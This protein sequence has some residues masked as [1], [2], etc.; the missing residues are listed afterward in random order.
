MKR[1]LVTF[2]AVVSLSFGVAA[3]VATV[4]DARSDNGNCSERGGTNNS[5][6]DKPECEKNKCNDDRGKPSTP[7]ACNDDHDDGHGHGHGGGEER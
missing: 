7:K 5:N 2:L 6:H 4:S 3:S 1:A